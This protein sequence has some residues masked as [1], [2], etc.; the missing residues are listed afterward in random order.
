MIY[1]SFDLES[2]KKQPPTILVYPDMI[3][4]YDCNVTLFPNK[5]RLR[6][7]TPRSFQLDV[8]SV[9]L[10]TSEVSDVP[11]RKGFSV[12]LSCKVPILIDCK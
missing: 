3:V 5:P 2:N 1:K 10:F 9:S 7:T 4:I 12:L 8:V 6:T 11:L